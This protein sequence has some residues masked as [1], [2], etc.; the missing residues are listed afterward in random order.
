M[1]INQIKSI[2][3]AQ[4][5]FKKIQM[6]SLHKVDLCKA[7]E[8]IACFTSLKVLEIELSNLQSFGSISLSQE[9]KIN[10]TRLVVN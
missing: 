10:L 4:M 6:L 7:D 1:E 5:T 2:E 9:A 8:F 3:D